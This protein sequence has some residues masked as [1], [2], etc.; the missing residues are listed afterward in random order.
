M[1][2]SINVREKHHKYT[3]RYEK[4]EKYHA[5]NSVYLPFEHSMTRGTFGKY[6]KMVRSAWVTVEKEK[7]KEKERM[8]KRI[9]AA[10]GF[11][12]RVSEDETSWRDSLS[13]ENLWQ[14]SYRLQWLPFKRVYIDR[15]IQAAVM[16]ETC[17]Q[18]L[19][20]RVRCLAF[21]GVKSR[22]P[23]TPSTL[24][25]LKR[26]AK[27]CDTPGNFRPSRIDV[28]RVIRFILPL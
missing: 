25:F 11:S 27:F 8:K 22:Q 23:P 2:R 28:E 9:A 5:L 3:Q 6:V 12:I 18:L 10:P 15:E 16:S 7:K 24:K 20:G 17:L 19:F 1:Y 26:R 21:R 4:R 13:C 14:L